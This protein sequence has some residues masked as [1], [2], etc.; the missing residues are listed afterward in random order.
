[1]MQT[2]LNFFKILKLKVSCNIK[3]KIYV[4]QNHFCL[5]EIQ[6][7]SISE[8]LILEILKNVKQTLNELKIPLLVNL[9]LTT[10]ITNSEFLC[11]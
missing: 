9:F 10:S 11:H 8:K 6:I 2:V 1:M 5:F 3:K 4:C 7:S